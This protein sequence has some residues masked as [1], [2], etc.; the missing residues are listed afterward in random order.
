MI[1]QFV[2]ETM[3]LGECCLIHSLHGKTRAC[4]I[5]AA[6]LMKKYQWP[7]DKCLSFINSKKEKIGMRESYLL[8]L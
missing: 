3:E 8:Q 7:L 2:E 5:T 6:Y 4:T 1:F